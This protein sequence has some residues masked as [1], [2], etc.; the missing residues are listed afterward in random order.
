M[1]RR[2]ERRDGGGKEEGCRPDKI[3]STRAYTR[4]KRGA[5]VRFTGRTRFI[6][7]LAVPLIG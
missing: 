2:E 5:K 3:K 7:E 1:R 6:N 4:G